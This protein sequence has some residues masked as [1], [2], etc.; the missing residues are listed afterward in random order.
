MSNLA[1]KDIYNLCKEVYERRGQ[2][3]VFEFVG[4]FSNIDWTWCEPC[5]QTSPFDPY[6]NP[7]NAKEVSCL[8]C[9]STNPFI[10]LT[11]IRVIVLHENGS[12]E[13]HNIRAD[14][15][16]G[17]L[18]KECGGYVE[19]K[20]LSAL[21][22]TLWFNEEAKINQKKYLPNFNATK[23]W[24]AQYGNSDSTVLLGNV[25]ITSNEVDSL[26]YP[27]SLTP[28]QIEHFMNV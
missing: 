21:N 2:Y 8:V 7:H 27:T 1:P 10:Q 24:V 17:L 9:G 26:G 25:V 3:G 23:L 19:A 18:Q 6:Y 20:E 14:K 22:I 15:T 4:N 28:A 5:E 16:L 13:I 11:M 12:T